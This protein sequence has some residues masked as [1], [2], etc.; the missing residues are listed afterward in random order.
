VNAKQ[1]LLPVARPEWVGLDGG[2]GIEGAITSVGFKES[3]DRVV[4]VLGV[5]I[6][7]H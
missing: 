7:I 3:L 6:R 4:G 2:N 5:I 1:G